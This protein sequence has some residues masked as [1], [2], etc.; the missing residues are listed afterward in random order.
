MLHDVD[1]QP[2]RVLLLQEEERY[3][4]DAIEALKGSSTF[5]NSACR[6]LYRVRQKIFSQ[7]LRMAG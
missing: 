1:E 3:C 4:D 5:H 6:K 2:E 7:V